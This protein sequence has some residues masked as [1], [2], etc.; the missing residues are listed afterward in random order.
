MKCGD[1]GVEKKKQDQFEGLFDWTVMA[2][3]GECDVLIEDQPRTSEYIEFIPMS[4]VVYLP[5][6]RIDLEV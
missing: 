6:A 3:D 1:F 2:N 4:L 5:D